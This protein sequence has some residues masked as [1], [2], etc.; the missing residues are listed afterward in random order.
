[1][2]PK[3][4]DPYIMA[5]SAFICLFFVFFFGFCVAIIQR[6]RAAAEVADLRAQ[7]AA[8]EAERET[9][10][11]PLPPALFATSDER[12]DERCSS[13]QGQGESLGSFRVTHY[14][15]CAKCCGVETGITASGR[16]AVSGYSVAVDPA[17]IP[18]GTR[19]LL[20][21]GDGVMHEARADD[22]G[23]AVKGQ[24]LDLC[25]ADHATALALGVREA[26]VYIEEDLK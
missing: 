1:M 4:D 3:H 7:V 26:T 18:L 14:C 17:V 6:D 19:L 21:Y 22:T 8:L 24:T 23:G 5:V 9:E 11:T 15:T 16:A 10:K 25:V 2:K 13:L 20:D 12:A